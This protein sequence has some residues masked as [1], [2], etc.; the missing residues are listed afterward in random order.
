[1]SEKSSFALMKERMDKKK[2]K[3]KFSPHSMKPKNMKEDNDGDDS[4]LKSVIKRRMKQRMNS[5]Y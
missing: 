2:K 1:M 5:D 3:G 4:G